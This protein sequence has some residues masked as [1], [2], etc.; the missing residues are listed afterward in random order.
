MIVG[1][2]VVRVDNVEYPCAGPEMLQQWLDCGRVARDTHI[3]DVEQQLWTQVFRVLR[4]ARTRSE[5]EICDDMDATLTGS[6]QLASEILELLEQINKK[7][8]NGNNG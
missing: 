6:T 5:S 3:F 7:K 2:Y 1:R 8:Q 4:T